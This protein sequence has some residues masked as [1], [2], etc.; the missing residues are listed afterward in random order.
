MRS[1]RAELCGKS[2][3]RRVNALRKKTL[4]QGTKLNVCGFS[5]FND[6]SCVVNKDLTKSD[7]LVLLEEGVTLPAVKRRKITEKDVK[8]TIAGVPR[9]SGESSSEWQEV[10]KYLDPNPQLKSQDS[11]ARKVYYLL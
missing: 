7:K 11:S 6:N 4:D 10:R 1:R 5:I 3:T 9:L 2:K 8:A